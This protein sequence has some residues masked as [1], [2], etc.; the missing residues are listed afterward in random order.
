MNE[1]IFRDPVHNYISV[2]DS[3]IY[4]LINTSEFQRL[5][6]IKQLATTSYTFHGAEHS[7]FSHCLGVYHIASRVVDYFEK[8]YPDDWNP[9]DS[10]LTMA[11]ALLHD[12]GHGAYSHTFER[13]F[14]TNHE[15]ITQEIITNNQTEVNAVLR[16]IAPDF[17]DKVAS[18]INHTYPNKQVEQL[19]SSQIDCDRMDYLLR[20]AYYTGASYGQFDLTRILSVIRPHGNGIAFTINGTHAIE[21]YLVS[22]Y[23]MYMQVYFHPAS[24]A[25]EV[26][27]QNLLKR[28][29]ALY[30]QQQAYFEKTSPCL[31]P[32]FEKSYSLQDYLY[33]DDGVMNT[34]F[35]SWMT[36]DDAILADLANRFINRKLFKSVILTQAS[37]TSLTALQKLVAAIGYDPDYYTAEHKNFDLPYDIYRPEKE[38]PRTQIELLQKDGSLK[39]LSQESD[40]V[41]ALT[42]TVHGDSRFYFPAEMLATDDLFSSEKEEFL[43][44]INNDRLL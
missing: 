22:R 16:R 24:R 9:D 3:L 1:K 23:Q 29:K 18:V 13:L 17:P 12:L 6:R 32:F 20:D 35:Q 43:G 5:R 14:D 10:L 28:A 34:Y 31:I 40:L 42:G 25:M 4:D 37:Q 36:S 21:D 44:H 39:E 27:L 2:T 41:K 7:R 11:A 26:L 33:L 38:N 19:I 15:A 8:H 30:P